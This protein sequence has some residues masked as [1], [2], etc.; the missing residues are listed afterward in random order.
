MWGG[1]FMVVPLISVHYVDGLGWAAS[2]IGLVLAL[3]QLTQQGLTVVGGMMADRLGAKGLIAAGMFI[4]A[5]SFFAM[6]WADSF[7]L[8][9]TSAFLAALGGALF[10]SPQSAAIAALTDEDNRARYYSL[11]GVVSGLGMTIGP[12][13]GALLLRFSFSLVALTAAACFFVAGLVTLWMMPQVQVAV[14]G[15]RLTYGVGLALR[16]RRFMAFNGLLMA[17]WFMWVQLTLSLPL[18]AKAVSGTADA[19]SWVYMLNAGMSVLL[20]YPVLR[21]AERRLRPMSI[22]VLG[23]LLM[24]LGLG[25]VAL[26]T[27]VPGL[28]LCVAGF[29]LGGLLA[30]PSQQTVKAELANPVAL[31]SYF[32]VS[33]LALAFGGGLGNYVGGLLYGLG[34]D[35]GWPTLPWM[36]F[37][38]VGLLGA[39]GLA[40]MRRRS[41]MAQPAG[42]G[43]PIAVGGE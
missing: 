7:P 37:G 11:I 33:A 20:Q 32:G 43:Q 18:Q 22:L 1:F 26:A 15:Q 42:D 9:L 41:V 2:A 3:R 17:Y 34:R 10:D 23:M 12:M 40:L 39:A 36:V 38:I 31:G 16:D 28:L 8:L 21:L 13:L 5:V 24:A 30:M 35:L 29:S 19:V 25:G 14:G 4:R 6:A 27:S